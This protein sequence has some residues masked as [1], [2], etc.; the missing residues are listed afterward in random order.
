MKEILKLMMIGLV[1]LAYSATAHAAEMLGVDI[2]GFLSQGYLNT[3]QYD[4]H[5]K[6]EDGS[7]EFNEVG[8]NFVADFYDDLL[9][10]M[11]LFSRDFADVDDSELTLDWAYADYRFRDWLGFRGGKLKIPQGLYNE[12]RDVDSLRTW[13]FLPSSVYS[14]TTRT[15]NLSMYAAGIYGN[16]S[17]GKLG[18]LS[19]QV[20]GGT[21]DLGDDNERLGYNMRATTI[22]YTSVELKDL[23]VDWRYALSM[24]WYTPVDGLRFSGTYN[25]TKASGEAT[26]SLQDTG[27]INATTDYSGVHYMV[28]SIEYVW[29]NL[30]LVAE[31][32]QCQ[33]EREDKNDAGL[34][35]LSGNV[36]QDRD[37]WYVGATYRFTDWLEIGGYYSESYND[38]EDRNGESYDPAHR[39]WLKDIC[40]TTMFDINDYF[41]IKLEGHHFNG[42]NGLFPLDNLPEEGEEWWGGDDGEDWTMIAAKATFTF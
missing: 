15:F 20:L 18:E 36:K 34:E 41:S 24:I 12:T 9:V 42:T 39:A 35:M 37:G 32:I 11:Q 31:Y 23:T 22:N 27:V 1:F 8:I 14:E 40:L 29:N 38:M 19:Y 17:L 3:S 7:F 10:G 28:G 6:T 5:G 4:Y 16:L 2:H 25:R 33:T 30:L 13:I 26:I 21:Q